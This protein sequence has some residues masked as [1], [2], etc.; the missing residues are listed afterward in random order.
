[1]GHFS[2][3]EK[4]SD[5]VE[6]MSEE[7]YQDSFLRS[8]KPHV[9]MITNHGIHDWEVVPGLPDT[10]GQNV[11]VNQMTDALA[12]LGFRVT[13]VNRGGYAH[14]KT[15]RMH[16]GLSYRNES[17]RILYLEDGKNAFVRKEDMADQV[18]GLADFLFDF[19]KREGTKVDFI[20][21]HYW[22][23]AKIGVL[24]NER[25]EKRL[26]HVWIPHSVGS[27]KK[28]NMEPSTW[29]SLRVDER[30]EEEK[31]FIPKLD[32]I[33]ATSSAIR[34][35]LKKDYGYE[36][37]LFLPPCVDTERFH[38][39][40]IGEGDP[41]WNFLSEASSLSA[42]EIRK[43]KIVT[44]I[45][46]TD[47]TKRKDVLIKA[48][49]AAHREVPESLLLVS[50]DFS[51]EA[52]A[53]ELK[54][55]VR[56]E[57]V[58]DSVVMVGSVWE[59]LPKLYAV[60]SVYCTPSVMEGFGMA[61]QE[62]AATG[63]PA[64]ASHL[65]PFAVEYLLGQD[66]HERVVEGSKN[67]IRQGEGAFVV[68]AD[69]VAGFAAALTLALKD[70]VLREKMSQRAY[71]ITIPYFTWRSMVVAFLKK[72]GVPCEGTSSSRSE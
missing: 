47:T 1:M 53:G 13:I 71:D 59:Y 38:S 55:L 72:M 60:T 4:E 50:V 69:D 25:L 6:Y 10:G 17:E 9:L 32:G 2:L 70:E 57:G 16:Q 39:R 22:D 66:V 41:I 43:R 11:F 52:L 42:E 65:V 27:L 24:F 12:K 45:S 61:I 8:E 56:Q 30:I 14:P 54:A 62:A 58:E 64:V 44:E 67:P 23:A 37:D 36:T 51:R 21:S 7:K 29:K 28:R 68:E 40:E 33:G 63:V 19:L 18:P 15:G 34:E 35:S 48:F 26:K 20:V 3:T 5:Y 49:A 46:R 31:A